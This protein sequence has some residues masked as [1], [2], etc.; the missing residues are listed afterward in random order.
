MCLREGWGGGGGSGGS[1]GSGV[2]VGVHSSPPCP[3]HLTPPLPPRLSES[4]GC[5][6]LVVEL[7]ESHES[8]GG[9]ILGGN[10]LP[11]AAAQT[12]LMTRV[13]QELVWEF[14]LITST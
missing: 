14:L 8:Q 4:R 1:D 2:I 10:V 7:P 6:L 9:R 5:N 11:S 12:I 13:V 3:F